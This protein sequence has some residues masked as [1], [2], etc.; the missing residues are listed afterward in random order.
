MTTN[1]Y[2]TL[3]EAKELIKDKTY[4]W[5]HLASCLN[6]DST[7][8][9]PSDIRG[10]SISKN[11]Q[12]AKQYCYECPVRTECL[13]YSLVHKLDLG[14]FGGLTPEERKGLHNKLPVRE[15]FKKK[16]SKNDKRKI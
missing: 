7:I 5:K 15:I 14:V 13:S 2:L 9:L 3:Y 4:E 16:D 1:E 8:F 6:L 10:R 11:Y 12:I